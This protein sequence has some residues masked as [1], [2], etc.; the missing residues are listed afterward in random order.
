MIAEGGEMEMTPDEINEI[1]SHIIEAQSLLDTAYS[2]DVQ[3]Q[4]EQLYLR[5]S[6]AESLV[7]IAMMLKGRLMDD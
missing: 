1:N 6:M 7:A 2:T 5:R 4:D 3:L